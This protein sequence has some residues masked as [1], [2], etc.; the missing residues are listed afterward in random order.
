MTIDFWKEE[1]LLAPD[2]EDMYNFIETHQNQ[3]LFFSHCLEIER[4][5]DLFY[6]MCLSGDLEYERYVRCEENL[7]GVFTEL[8]KKEQF[9][10]FAANRTIFNSR[11][12]KKLTGLDKMQLRQLQNFC[13]RKQNIISSDDAKKLL[14]CVTRGLAS[15]CALAV[16]WKVLMLMQ[17]L[18]GAIVIG[19]DTDMDLV[20]QMIKIFEKN[21]FV[22]S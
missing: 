11:R 18:H 8:L 15:T 13:G 3:S 22:V 20:A 10:A 12:A 9:V 2:F 6:Q 14:L 16:D 21:G 5:S 7:H 19:E 4:R 1:Y 17:D